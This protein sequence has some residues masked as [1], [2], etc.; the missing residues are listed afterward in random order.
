M[1]PRHAQSSLLQRWA[2]RGAGRA[3]CVLLLLSLAA[4]AATE[5]D[6]WVH[7]VR[8]STF[9]EL[10]GPE[11]WE[12]QHR[13]VSR[14]ENTC[15]APARG[16]AAVPAAAG[17]G[18]WLERGAGLKVNITTPFSGDTH[19]VLG[20]DFVVIAAAADGTEEEV[21][22]GVCCFAVLM[23]DAEE[24]RR[25]TARAVARAR[26]ELPVAID[27]NRVAIPFGP[28]WH[29][30][31]V[32]IVPRAA[33]AAARAEA[34]SEA[35]GA[36]DVDDEFGGEDSGWEMRAARHALATAHRMVRLTGPRQAQCARPRPSACPRRRVRS[37]R[38]EGRGVSDQYGLRD[39][40][41][42]ISTR[43]G[44]CLPAAAGRW[45]PRRPAAS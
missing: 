6:E 11:Q 36:G 25:L 26:A 43:G 38:G 16:G 31:R 4:R 42:P 1:A 9:R 39:A 23:L 14:G 12:L 20:V 24:P 29:I 32:A 27:R 40:A 7:V 5:Q 8:N 18:S 35:R 22:W 15:A 37:V 30:L 19:L 2:R 21:D 44:V 33:E 41:C 3:L 45:R 28:T 10:Y 13:R 17:S 34:L